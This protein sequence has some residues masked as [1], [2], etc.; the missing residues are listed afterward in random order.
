[1][2]SPGGVG[3]FVRL[4]DRHALNW[5]QG[6]GGWPR[7]LDNS[8]AIGT[9]SSRYVTLTRGTPTPVDD[10]QVLKGQA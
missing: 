9:T 5:L 3:Q 8:T 6:I 7:K 2:L 4:G 10:V 1:M